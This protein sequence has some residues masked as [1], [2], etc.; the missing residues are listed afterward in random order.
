MT[1]IPLLP[2]YLLV[3]LAHGDAS[4][5]KER[6]VNRLVSSL[7]GHIQQDGALG[8]RVRL[9]V[10]GLAPT[11]EG[12]IPAL[13]LP[14][15]VGRGLDLWVGGTLAYPSTISRVCEFI[16]EDRSKRRR[17]GHAFRPPLVLLFADDPYGGEDQA[18][19]ATKALQDSHPDVT[20]RWI[21]YSTEHQTP[22]PVP[23]DAFQLALRAIHAY[24]TDESADTAEPPA[25]PEWTGEFVPF[26]VG[27]PGRAAG[28]VR[29]KPDPTEWDR[30]DTV[31]DG[32]RIVDGDGLPAVELRAA[33]VRGLS[34]RFYGTVRQDEYAF[35]TT[36]DGRYLVAVVSDGV[37]NSKLS[38]KAA[39]LIGR[40]GGEVVADA[41]ATAP[42]ERI[43]WLAVVHGLADEIVKLGSQIIGAPAD[44]QPLGHREVAAHLAA[45]A[46]FA[47]VDLRPVDDVMWV[48]TVA[49]G[50][51]AAWVLRA[52]EAWEPLRAVKN[53]GSAVAS[54]TTSALPLKPAEVIPV[55]TSLRRADALVLMS[56]GVG[57]PLGDGTGVVGR[58]LASVWGRPPEPLAFAAQVDFARRTHDDDRTVL[59]VWPE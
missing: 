46:L 43:D 22:S 40:K 3:D 17:D 29:P 54:A 25:E 7:V 50:D 33:S 32:V 5:R 36:A 47:V 24:A 20:F 6:A 4:L 10:L 41:L 59:A 42:P 11:T 53:E 31:V 30:R 14:E 37:S 35:R 26:A 56:D 48:H 16:G 15:E 2:I 8:D 18:A 9:H 19:A 13:R 55:V 44:R 27:H 38:H 1:T 12:P 34:H 39:V 57:D 45:T 28:V 23:D 21:L 49:V 52:G 58:F 51:S